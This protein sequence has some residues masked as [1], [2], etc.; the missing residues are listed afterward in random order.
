[1]QQWIERKEG[2]PGRPGRINIP[3]DGDAASEIRT[4]GLWLARQTASLPALREAS[5]A[6]VIGVKT[7]RSALPRTKKAHGIPGTA[8]HKRI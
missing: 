6:Q 1:M 2:A 8:R 4:P 3:K 7:T 5:S